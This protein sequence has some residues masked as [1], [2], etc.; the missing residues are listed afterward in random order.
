MPSAWQISPS[1]TLDWRT[2]DGINNLRLVH[3]VPKPTPGPNEVLV[4]IKAAALNARDIMVA[5][6]NPIYPAIA[7]PN[8]S[9]LADGAGIV[10]AVGSGSKWSVGD[11]V[12]IN[13]VKWFDGDVPTFD[14]AEGGGSGSYEGTLR[15][16]GVYVSISIFVLKANLTI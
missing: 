16:Y 4:N 15:E 6:H 14:E 2:K 12:L 8:L 7:V 11:R 3:D 1:E 10:E 9:P 13:P 5:A